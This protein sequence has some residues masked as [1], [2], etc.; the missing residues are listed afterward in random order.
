MRNFSFFGF[1]V[2]HEIRNKLEHYLVICIA[3]FLLAPR[4]YFSPAHGK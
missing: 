3:I 2:I 1:A 4:C